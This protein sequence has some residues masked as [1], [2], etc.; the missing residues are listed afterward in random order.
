MYRQRE[1]ETETERQSQNGPGQRSGSFRLLTSTR[2]LSQDHSGESRPDRREVA[3]SAS[4]PDTSPGRASG[5]LDNPS[6]SS[7]P[8]LSARALLPF[9]TFLVF[10]GHEFAANFFQP[11]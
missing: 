2:G 3:S 10:V 4:V 1:T 11:K 8:S 7:S 6:S 9:Y 5:A